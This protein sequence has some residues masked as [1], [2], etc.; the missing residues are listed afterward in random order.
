MQ[1]E[2]PPLTV[3]APFAPAFPLPWAG[4]SRAKTHHVQQNIHFQPKEV[5]FFLQLL[6]SFAQALH[7]PTIPC[8]AS[9]FWKER[10]KEVK[11]RTVS[12]PWL[13]QVKTSRAA[14]YLPPTGHF[15]T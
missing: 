7:F 4:D 6:V 8:E 5:V 10:K 3:P 11:I 14:L 9:R 1:R 12:Q 15:Q 13:L 2:R